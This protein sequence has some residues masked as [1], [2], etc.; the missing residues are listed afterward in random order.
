VTALR[1]HRRPLRQV[2]FTPDGKSLLSG[3]EGGGIR[4]TQVATQ[5]ELLDLPNS[6]RGVY[7]LKIS[8]TSRVLGVLNARG[9]IDILGP[10]NRAK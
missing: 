8:P 2:A 3:D 6:S 10:A 9:A 7:L 1:N 4:I 5:S